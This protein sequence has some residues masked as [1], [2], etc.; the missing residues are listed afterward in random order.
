MNGLP[1]GAFLADWPQHLRGVSDGMSQAF[2]DYEAAL[3]QAPDLAE[4]RIRRPER[5]RVGRAPRF[6]GA[7]VSRRSRRGASIGPHRG[8]HVL[9]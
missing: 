7:R 4:T 9:A 5:E 2:V 8:P 3:L 6:T 1:P